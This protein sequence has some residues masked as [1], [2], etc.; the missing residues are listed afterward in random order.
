MTHQAEALIL[1]TWPVQEADLIV[2]LLTRDQGRIKGIAKSGAKSRK[3]FGGALEPMTYVL[4]SYAEKPRQE[5]VRLDSCEILASP[6]SAPIDYPRAA[7]LAFYAEVLEET[8]PER[9]PQDA[10]FRL[11]LAVL[12]QTRD[13]HIWLPVTYFA[14]WILRLMGWM[15]EL[16]RCIVCGRAL[17]GQPAWYQPHADGLLCVDHRQLSSRALAAP[18][19]ELANRIFHAPIAALISHPWSSGLAADLR[20]FAF[21]SLER[22]LERRLRTSAALNKLAS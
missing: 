21:Q 1:R 3:R 16:S 18:S 14:L 20:R 6:L 15:P 8:L 11:A 22:H 17:A 13:G 5:L 10:V 7:A 4:A 2:S 19:L 9:D 12:E